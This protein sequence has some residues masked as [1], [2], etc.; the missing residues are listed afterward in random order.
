MPAVL[1]AVP[2]ASLVEAGT[3]D[4]WIG[5][6]RSTVAASG[7]CRRS[8]SSLSLHETGDRDRD[9]KRRGTAVVLAFARRTEPGSAATGCVAWTW[10]VRCVPAALHMTPHLAP[11]EAW[12]PGISFS[13]HCLGRY[14]VVWRSCWNSDAISQYCPARNCCPH[15][16][17]ETGC[18]KTAMVPNTPAIQ[19]PQPCAKRLL[20]GKL[21]SEIHHVVWMFGSR[22]GPQTHT[23][24]VMGPSCVRA[25]VGARPLWP[26]LAIVAGASMRAV[27]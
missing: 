7:P 11:Q 19:A 22:V 23:H 2:A 16:S 17:S 8:L 13:S 18:M 6:I 26:S 15:T 9:G 1:A 27:G 25:V 20:R 14:V 10:S 4:S 21:H 12:R 24:M 3:P 5:A